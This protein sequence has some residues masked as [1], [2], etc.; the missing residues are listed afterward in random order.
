MH[1]G[2]I[3]TEQDLI[4]K[5][6]GTGISPKYQDWVIGRALKQDLEEDSILSW[7]DL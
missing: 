4:A 5:R 1:A 6:P 7:N 3:L 2:D